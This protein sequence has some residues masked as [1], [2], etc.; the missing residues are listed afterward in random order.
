ME[1]ETIVESNAARPLLI[2]KKR[3]K[4]IS[5]QEYIGTSHL[6][7]WNLQQLIIDRVN[8][9]SEVMYG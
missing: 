7:E 3:T 2:V 8:K 4:K 5:N 6:K 1:T 9:E